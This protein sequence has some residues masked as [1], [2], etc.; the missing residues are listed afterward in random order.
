M[1]S[2][3]VRINEMWRKFFDLPMSDEFVDLK[4]EELKEAEKGSNQ[5]DGQHNIDAR[6]AQQYCCTI[7]W[8]I[9]A[10]RPRP[11]RSKTV[12]SQAMCDEWAKNSGAKARSPLLK[13]PC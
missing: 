7:F 9:N 2:M 13:G 5:R 4:L 6:L 8:D 11:D 1:N 3:F 10:P 12:T